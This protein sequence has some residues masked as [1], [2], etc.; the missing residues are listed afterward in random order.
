MVYGDAPTQD[1]K[2]MDLFGEEFSEEE[3]NEVHGNAS[4]EDDNEEE[5]DMF[6]EDNEFFDED[7]FDGSYRDREDI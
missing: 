3:F 1:S 6:D 7:E 2:E 5:E 4:K